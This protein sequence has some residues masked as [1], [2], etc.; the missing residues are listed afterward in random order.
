M[1]DGL[2]WVLWHGENGLVVFQLRGWQ[3]V[4]RFER[5]CR[6]LIGSRASSFRLC[7]GKKRSLQPFVLLLLVGVPPRGLICS[8]RLV[9]GWKQAWWFVVVVGRLFCLPLVA[10]SIVSRRLLV[11]ISLFFRCFLVRYSLGLRSTNERRTKAQRE[12]NEGRARSDRE[13][14]EKWLVVGWNMRLN[15]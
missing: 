8:T 4:M 3:Q 6:I 5:F 15:V 1:P 7:V 14:N 13:A 12:T 10:V 9:N 11:V 2:G